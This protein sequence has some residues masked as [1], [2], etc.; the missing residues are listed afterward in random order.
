MSLFL[1]WAGFGADTGSPAAELAGAT[2]S[3]V[4]LWAPLAQL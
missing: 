2:G 4:L 3:A 1:H